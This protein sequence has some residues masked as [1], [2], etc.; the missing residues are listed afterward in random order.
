M[1]KVIALIDGEHYLPVVKAGI[2]AIRAEHDVCAAVFL[3]GTEKVADK[4]DYSSLGLPVLFGDDPLEVMLSA[5][6]EHRPD[7]VIDLSDEPVLTYADRMRLASYALREGVAYRGSD[8]DFSPPDFAD[9]VSTPSISIIGTGKRVGK[10]A[11]SAY[12]S[13]EL[14]RAGLNPCVIAMGRGGPPEPELL[15][16][17]EVQLTADDLLGFM[18]KGQHAA[19]DNFEDAVMSRVITVG[20]RRCG[21]GMAGAP[22]ISNVVEGARMADT[23]G[24]GILVFEGSGATLP[25]VRTDA[26]ILI[27]GAHQPIE[28]IAGYFGTYRV[29]LADLV[30]LTMCE[31]PMASPDK[32]ASVSS[33]VGKLRED[34]PILRTVFRP[35]PI[36]PIASEKVFF[37]TTA[38]AQ[39]VEVLA[40]FLREESGCDVV[41]ASPHLSNRPL[42]RADIEAVP[43]FDV[44]LT[45]LKAAS[46]DVATELATEM[47]KRVVYCDNEPVVV[48]G[49]ASALSEAALQ[50]A[51]RVAGTSE[52]ND[53]PSSDKES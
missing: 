38:P 43:D 52:L 24:A 3:G 25:P 39:M 10:T 8:F 14:K 40:R 7:T 48:D 45:E 2:D 9:V 44:M 37:A 16:G 41:G 13:R 30:V 47:G 19:S 26:S 11:V 18:R 1:D 17:D 20:C 15:R 49:S 36:E 50:L 28:H 6:A 53:T 29:L 35:R 27:C 32:I 12:I 51:R 4:G 42:L 34:V 22:Y 21:G 23:L 31:E 5:I 46:V 33:A